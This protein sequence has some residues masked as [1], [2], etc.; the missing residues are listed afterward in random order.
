MWMRSIA[1]IGKEDE[2]LETYVE[3]GAAAED[4]RA[5]STEPPDMTSVAR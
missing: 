5:Q 2:E 4:E 3:S 1:P